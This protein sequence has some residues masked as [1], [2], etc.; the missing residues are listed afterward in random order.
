MAGNILQ[1]QKEINREIDGANNRLEELESEEAGI[2]EELKQLDTQ[3]P[4]F[5]VLSE[6]YDQLEKLEKLGGS[7]LFWGENYE[8]EAV[9]KEQ[10][11]V[12]DLIIN[13]DSRV[14]ELL[15]KQ[16]T[17]EDAVESLTAKIIILNEDTLSLQERE[18]ELLEEFVI[19]REMVETPFRVM[20]MPWNKNDKDQKQF[21]KVLLLVLFFSILL[22]ILFI[23][24]HLAWYSDSYMGHPDP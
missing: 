14:A 9:T 23:F 21:R 6:V 5:A 22:G 7:D 11:R 12:H 3:R 17:R 19:E 8:R 10:K 1:Q 24:L 18:E 20:N 16:N 15:A 2:R 13:Y 4:R